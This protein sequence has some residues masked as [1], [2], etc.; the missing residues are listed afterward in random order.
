MRENSVIRRRQVSELLLGVS[1]CG[2]MSPLRRLSGMSDTFRHPLASA[3]GEGFGLLVQVGF[4]IAAFTPPAYLRGSL[5]R[6]SVEVSSRRR[7][8]A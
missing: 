8:R 7:L 5:P 2:I 6:P 1:P 3:R 4:G